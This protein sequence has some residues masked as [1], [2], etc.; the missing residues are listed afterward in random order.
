M[1]RYRAY[2]VLEDCLFICFRAFICSNDEDAIVWAK[3]QLDG[4]PIEL[5][6]EGR[7]V[8]RLETTSIVRGT[9]SRRPPPAHSDK[10]PSSNTRVSAGSNRKAMD[11]ERQPPADL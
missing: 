4:S 7:F 6:D 3:H 9:S 2:T 1:Q 11:H 5:W 8:A 10:E